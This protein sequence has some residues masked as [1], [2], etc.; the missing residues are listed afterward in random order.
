MELF[1]C[2]QLKQSICY[3]QSFSEV[4]K[5]HMILT[6]IN[7]IKWQ[8]LFFFYLLMQLFI[9]F[10]IYLIY[11][12]SDLWWH[13]CRQQCKQKELTEKLFKW[14]HLKHLSKYVFPIYPP[15]IVRWTFCSNKRRFWRSTSAASK[16][17]IENFYLPHLFN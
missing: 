4:R 15:F 10:Y 8:I 17:E 13:L 3:F 11:R 6:K 14:Y 2:G 5:D 7:D 12:N 1:V 16:N 9:I